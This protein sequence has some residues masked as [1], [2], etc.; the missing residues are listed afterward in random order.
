MLAI[1]ESRRPHDEV[2][3]RVVLHQRV[4]H[5]LELDRL[6]LQHTL[7]GDVVGQPVLDLLRH[8]V[9]GVPASL[10][11]REAIVGSLS[12]TSSATLSQPC[13]A[14]S[15]L[16]QVVVRH[17]CEA[18]AS[19]SIRRCSVVTSRTMATTPSEPA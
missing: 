10:Q 16:F 12:I 13:T 6:G 14:A 1:T 2:D 8:P 19:S 18:C 3:V 17:R 11:G 4:Q 5:R 9:R 15:G 7:A